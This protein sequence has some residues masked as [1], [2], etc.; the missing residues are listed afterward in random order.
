[1]I[2]LSII[3]PVFNVEKYIR[4]CIETIYRQ[5]LDEERFEVIIINDGTMDKSMEVIEDIIEERNI[6]G[7]WY[8]KL[9]APFSICILCIV[10]SLKKNPLI[11]K[12]KE[13]D[14]KNKAILRENK[15]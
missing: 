14:N 4:L 12:Y 10:S 13:N 15:L 5:K 11:V 6:W 8:N 1:M 7:I 2:Q 9:K 3:V